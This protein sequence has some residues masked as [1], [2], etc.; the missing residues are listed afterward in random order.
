MQYY[1]DTNL[2]L[3]YIHRI[4]MR[5]NDENQSHD[6]HHCSVGKTVVILEI[7]L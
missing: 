2:E 6:F 4:Q 5:Y 1:D 7:S 3:S